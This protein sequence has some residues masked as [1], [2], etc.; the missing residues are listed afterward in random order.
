LVAELEGR[1]VGVGQVR[2]HLDGSREL[3]SLAVAPD[4]RRRGI[5]SQLVKAL[6]AREHG[7]LHLFCRRGLRGYYR[8]FGFEV[9]QAE[10][11][12]WELRLLHQLSQAALHL[13]ARLGGP[14]WSI[15]A[16]ARAEPE[17]PQE[18]G[19]NDTG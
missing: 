19:W 6:L 1:I 18:G 14:R 4:V 15:L 7:P 3:A 2:P 12:G 17:A 13:L 11:L 16:M 9:V 8:R 5:G 10:A